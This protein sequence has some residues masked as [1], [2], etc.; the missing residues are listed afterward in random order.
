M[1]LL[2]LLKTEIMALTR[3][4]F[5]LRIPEE[6]IVV[7]D[8]TRVGV[9]IGMGR[10]LGDREVDLVLGIGAIAA[11]VA[12]GRGV[13]PKPLITPLAIDADVQ[14]FP[15]D[16]A[17]GGTRIVWPPQLETSAHSSRSIHFRSWR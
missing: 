3:N 9:E 1:N 8:W 10:L 11:D 6:K 2:D 17:T 13:I 16:P 7:A 12:A 5:D 15:F 4:E 14:G